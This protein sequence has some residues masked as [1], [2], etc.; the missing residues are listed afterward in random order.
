MPKALGIVLLI[1]VLVA[2]PVSRSEGAPSVAA[3]DAKWWGSLSRDE[4]SLVLSGYHSGYERGRED[5]V[6]MS[7][8]ENQK[9]LDFDMFMVL[10]GQKERCILSIDALY[11]S[12]ANEMVSL[13]DAVRIG[14][15]MVIGRNTDQQLATARANGVARRRNFERLLE[16][17]K[18]RGK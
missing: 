16:K 15:E 13:S 9:R 2:V 1:V 3:S 18:G 4:K 5:S 17:L 12:D 8:R 6:D 11:A 7:A 14:V 10:N